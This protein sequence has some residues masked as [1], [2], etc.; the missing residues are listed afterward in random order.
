M[1]TRRGNGSDGIRRFYERLLA[2]YPRSFQE[3]YGADLLQLFDD[4]RREPRF[5]GALGS[6]RLMWFILRDFLRSVPLARANRSETPGWRDGMMSDL[7]R[8]LRYA[9][10]M[11]VKNPLFTVA[12]VMTLALGI[13]LNTAT[14][15]AVRGLLL[16]PLDGA[17]DPDQLVQIYRKWP[18]MDYG[19][20]SVPHYQD[21][22]DRS[23]DAFS[24]VAAWYFTP[25]SVSAGGRS[26]RVIGMVVSANF[27]QTY[28]VTPVLGRAFIPGVEDRDP[29]AHP[30]AILGN[31]FWHARFGGDPS[32]IGRSMVL[33]GQSFEVVGV[34]PADF[35]GPVTIA[36]PPIYVPLMEQMVIDPGSDLIHARGNNMMTAV[37]RLRDGS[38]IEHAGQVMSALLAQL[39]E[40]HPNDYDKQ[41]GTT[42]VPQA[43]AGIHPQFQSAQVGMS[44]VMM[45]VVSLL[46][47]IACVNVAN[48]FLARA[49]G[50]R[51]EMGIRLSLGAGR[52]R[53]LQQLLIESLLFSL[54]A[55]VAGL[56]LAE[57]AVHLLANVRPPMEAPWSFAV[58][59]DSTVLLFTLGISLGTGLIFGLVPALHTTRRDTV[60]AVKGESANA[61]GR[62]RMSSALIVFQ[63]AL[64]LILLI[65]SGL[66]LRSLQGATHI[67]PGFQDPGHI[68]P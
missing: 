34:A 60:S 29:G 20:V 32:V 67:D 66:F 56:G 33:N 24:D 8:D 19:S 55:G 62:S 40:E 16:R 13:G 5:R 64:S 3:R 36:S 10:R 2:L 61:A 6:V 25:M 58:E 49:R 57:I 28:G 53:I 46:L 4:R 52:R 26:E 45:V 39:R 48:L 14:F 15:S 1:S 65:S 17:R 50:R 63:M 51:R 30:V 23:G 47:L 68:A 7:G 44:A 43:E 54:V 42:L 35:R 11:L 37:A 12:A 21:L 31:G 41:I 38:T 18:G 59:I 27:F 22:R 9:V